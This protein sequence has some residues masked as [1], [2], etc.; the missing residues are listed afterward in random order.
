M[1]IGRRWWGR[2][3]ARP[4]AVCIRCLDWL[5]ARGAQALATRCYPYLVISLAARRPA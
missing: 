4:A 2:W 1:Q 5:T 3:L